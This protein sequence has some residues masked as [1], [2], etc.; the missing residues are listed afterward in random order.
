[1]YFIKTILGVVTILCYSLYI[2][3]LHTSIL[4][5]IILTNHCSFINPN[6]ELKV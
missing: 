5:Y 2:C 6:K 3:Y 4:F 1:M